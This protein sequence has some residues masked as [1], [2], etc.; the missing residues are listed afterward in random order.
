MKLIACESCDAE[1]RIKHDLDNRLYNIVHCPFC[2]DVLNEDLKDE[3]D[4]N[5]E[6]D[7]DLSLIHI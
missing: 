2:G 3:V 7:Y 4:D 1:F 5:Y 6:E